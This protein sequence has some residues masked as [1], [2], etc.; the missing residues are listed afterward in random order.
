MLSH[1]EYRIAGRLETLGL[2]EKG[3]AHY[4][5][6]IAPFIQ[7]FGSGRVAE[8]VCPCHNTVELDEA[9]EEMKKAWQIW[10]DNKINDGILWVIDAVP[11]VILSEMGKLPSWYTGVKTC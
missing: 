4:G 8:F 6:Q 3:L 5:E 10:Q 2:T 9:I 7:S 1:E 11:D